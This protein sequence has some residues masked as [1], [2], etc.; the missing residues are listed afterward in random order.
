[1]ADLVQVSKAIRDTSNQLDDDI[2]TL[3]D[4]I[5]KSAKAEQKYRVALSR[6]IIELKSE[7]MPVTLIADVARGSDEVSNVKFNRDL[8]T[9]TYKASK[10]ILKAR[11]A[12]LSSLQTLIKYQSDIEGGK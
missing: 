6:K 3:T 5:K 7:K 8:E 11:E 4:K 10:E 2:K 9:E 1:M 12:Q